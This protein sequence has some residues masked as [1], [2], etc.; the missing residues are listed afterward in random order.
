M[1]IQNEPGSKMGLPPHG[2]EGWMLAYISPFPPLPHVLM[3]PNIWEAEE[4]GCPLVSDACI[5]KK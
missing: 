3:V 4:G 2:F 5:F 1:S